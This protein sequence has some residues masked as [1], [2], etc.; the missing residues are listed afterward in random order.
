[1]ALNRVGEDLQ[2]EVTRFDP[3]ISFAADAGAGVATPGWL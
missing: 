3:F 2:F 1:M